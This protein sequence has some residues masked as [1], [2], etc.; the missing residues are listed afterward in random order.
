MCQARLCFTSLVST[1]ETDTETDTAVATM[2]THRQSK[3]AH[4]LDKKPK[5]PE[6]EEWYSAIWQ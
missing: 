2:A 4:A 3:S 6:R 5:D 1:V